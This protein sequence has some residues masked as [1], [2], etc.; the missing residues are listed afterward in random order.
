SDPHDLIHKAAGWMLREV[1]MRD[2]ATLEEFLKTHHRA[3][4]RTMLRYAIERFPPDVHRAYLTG[5]RR[6]E[7]D[8][9]RRGFG[10][11]MTGR[12]PTP[13][14]ARRALRRSHVIAGMPVTT[15]APG[16][17]PNTVRAADGTI[18]TAPEGWVLLPPGDAGLTR[19]VKAAGD[20]LVVQE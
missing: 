17:T 3:M 20:H 11:S 9:D 16:P 1:G 10:R 8:Q 13:P 6:P 7:H 2:R 15:F 4:P 18:L 14:L 12:M 5:S 19:R